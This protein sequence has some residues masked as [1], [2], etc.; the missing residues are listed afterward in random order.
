MGDEGDDPHLYQLRLQ[1]AIR[2]AED[3]LRERI[4]LIAPELRHDVN[5]MADL[6]RDCVK[7]EREKAG[8]D[9]PTGSIEL[10]PNESRSSDQAPHLIGAGTVAGRRYE[11]AAWL[12]PNNVLRVALIKPRKT[13]SDASG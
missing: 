9:N 11:A 12:T 1:A 2:E 7:L 6:I 13:N 5:V 10:H 8:L 3:A 4:L